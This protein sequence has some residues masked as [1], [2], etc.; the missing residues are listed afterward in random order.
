MEIL[1]AFV[2]DELDVIVDMPDCEFV[3]MHLSICRDEMLTNDLFVKLDCPGRQFC[4]F[5]F[6][7]QFAEIFKLVA[8]TLPAYHFWF[9]LHQI[10]HQPFFRGK[11]VQKTHLDIDSAG[12]LQKVGKH[13]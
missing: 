8:S 7:K 4:F 5:D 13:L 10:L 12:D 3:R 11:T 1:A 6:Q 9:R 2:D